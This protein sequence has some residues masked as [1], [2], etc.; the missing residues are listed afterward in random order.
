MA[1][2]TASIVPERLDSHKLIRGIHDPRQCR[3]GRN[4]EKKGLRL[5]TGCMMKRPRRRFT[6][7]QEFLENPRHALCQDR[8]VAA[9]LFNRVLAQVKG[10]DYE[11]LVN[12]VV[13]RSQAAGGISA[14]NYG[15]F[16]LKPAALCAFHFTD[17]RYA[18]L[19]VHRALIRGLGLA[20]ARYR[21]TRR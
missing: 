3:G 14:E 18:D 6:T 11:P 7:L 8:R 12:E 9:A 1:R 20:K 4:V 19:I 10:E 13:L 2:S 21:R 5:S 15:H 17:R 16:G